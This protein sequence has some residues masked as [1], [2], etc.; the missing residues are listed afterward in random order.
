MAGEIDWRFLAAF[1]K[2]EE[3]GTTPTPGRIHVLALEEYLSSHGR[4]W[5]YDWYTVVEYGTLLGDC[6]IALRGTGNPPPPNPPQ[7]L[8]GHVKDSYGNPAAD[9]RVWLYGEDGSLLASGKTDAAGYYE[10]VDPPP[11]TCYMVVES[12][13]ANHTTSEFYYPHV[14][15]ERN[16]TLP[17]SEFLPN[18]ALLVLDDDASGC[19]D[20][21]VWPSEFQSVLQALGF[22]VFTWSERDMGRPSLSTLLNKNVTLV[23]WHAGTYYNKVV[24]DVDSSTL[25]DFVDSG[26][27]LLLEGEDIGYDHGNDTFMSEV[28]HAAFLA[29]SVS[30]PSL[31]TTDPFHP[32]ING[33]SE[34]PFG[35]TPPYP[36]GV[37]PVGGGEGLAVYKDTSYYSIIAYDGVPSGEGCRIV[38]LSFPVH[39]LNQSARETLL[40]NALKWL[41]TSYYYE[42]AANASGVVR[43]SW[44]RV[45]HEL[46]NGTSPLPGMPVRALVYFPDGSLE[47][48]YSMTDL[49]DGRYVLDLYIEEDWPTGI[50]RVRVESDI[51]G[52]GLV[53]DEVKLKVSESVEF[54]ITLESVD[55][56]EGVVHVSVIINTTASALEE[57]YFSIDGGDGVPAPPADGAFDEPVEE[58]VVEYNASQLAE[59][60]HVMSIW[61]CALG[62]CSESLNL[63]MHV[64]TLKPRYSI[65]ALILRPYDT[66][67]ASDFAR[68]VG[69]ALEG[70]WKWVWERQDFQAYVPGVTEEDFEMV[71]GEGYF[72]YLER[73]AKFVEVGER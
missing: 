73:E 26:G 59:G 23:V 34:F 9:A 20:E 3:G 17:P 13:G 71:L 15:L 8:Y 72:V 57:A 27:R 41:A 32:V 44:V 55:V 37:E 39:Y 24:D 65:I 69:P 54:E 1:K 18:T 19:V 22:N 51:V 11:E 30:A 48:E 63:T 31:E 4:D 28:A 14:D 12:R 49:G 70:V 47:G 21:G 36:D 38:Y 42:T 66:Y 67:M 43:G 35:T 10:F 29:D 60:Y 33:T 46:Y 7:R 40:K 2:L 56:V 50:Y 68:A 52:Y 45:T 6:T 64:R 58:V 16:I 53:R 61:G 25:M 62:E 5:V